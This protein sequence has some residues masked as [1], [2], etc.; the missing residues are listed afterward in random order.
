MDD[1]FM[2]FL[3][4]FQTSQK[5]CSVSPPVVFNFFTLQFFNEIL[6]HRYSEVW[7]CAEGTNKIFFKNRYALR[8]CD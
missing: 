8:T 5:W 6:S 1:F 7:N 4:K 2:C 3:L